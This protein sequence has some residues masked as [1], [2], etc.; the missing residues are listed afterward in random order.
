MKS[1][2]LIA[3]ISPAQCRAARALL[4]WTQAE[5]AERASLS[6]KTVADFEQENRDVHVRT[7]HDIATTLERAGVE[8][9]PGGVRLAAVAKPLVEATDGASEM[10]APALQ[11]AAGYPDAR[12]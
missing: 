11:K 6:R 8:F 1:T 10:P 4:A 12:G 3:V 5:L 2:T 9:L 7:R